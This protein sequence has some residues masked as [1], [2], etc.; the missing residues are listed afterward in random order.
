MRM[1]DGGEAELIREL[2][3]RACFALDSGDTEGWVSFFTEDVEWEA[4]GVAKLRGRQEMRDLHK[5]YAGGSVRARHVVGNHVV[6]VRGDSASFR[7]YI[8]V[9]RVEQGA[10]IKVMTSGSYHY[11][12]AKT[13]GV[14]LA[15]RFKFALDIPV[16][17]DHAQ[18][19]RRGTPDP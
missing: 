4:E 6:D 12:F 9:F 17:E 10:E 16:L 2:V 7:S 18:A 13:D 19:R 1:A 11:E 3:A 15:R 14:W 5:R 8:T